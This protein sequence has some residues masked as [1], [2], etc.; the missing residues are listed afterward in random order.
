MLIS[1]V[2]LSKQINEKGKPLQGIRTVTQ[3]C[4]QCKLNCP[5]LDFL[6]WRGREEWRYQVGKG[7]NWIAAALK[8]HIDDILQV[9]IGE[10]LEL[11]SSSEIQVGFTFGRSYGSPT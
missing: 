6:D 7:P 2:Q 5:I 8:K 4:Y 11:K 3:I 1:L 9:S 10:N